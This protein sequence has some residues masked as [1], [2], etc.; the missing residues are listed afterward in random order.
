MLWADWMTRLLDAREAAEVEAPREDDEERPA[1]A[2]DEG[3]DAG[4]GF[5]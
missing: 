3:T 4:A 5:A 1:P 2:A